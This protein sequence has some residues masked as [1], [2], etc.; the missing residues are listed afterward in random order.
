MES[1]HNRDPSTGE[2]VVNQG[3]T[4]NALTLVT[5]VQKETFKVLLIR[6][7]VG[8]QIA[9]FMME[10]K[11]FRDL[12]HCL[13][14][15]VAAYLPK[16]TATI[17]RWIMAAYTQRKEDLKEELQ[18]SISKV[19]IAFDIWTA[20]NWIGVICL[21]GYWADAAGKRQRRLLAFR[22]IYHSHDG[23]N[24]AAIIL[25]VLKEYEIASNVGYFV[26]DNHSANDSAIVIVLSELDPAITPTEIEG[27][28]LR[29]FGH[30]VNLAAQSLLDPS[31][32][33]LAVAAAELE[34]D[35]EAYE[36]SID[37][38]HAKGPLGKVCRLV[39]YVLASPQRREEF[40]AIK[41]GKKVI[42]YDHL[43]VS[44]D[45]SN[46]HELR[47]FTYEIHSFLL[48]FT[49]VAPFRQLNTLE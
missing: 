17:R 39:K 38:W 49:I 35:E 27:R 19:H 22:R 2:V 29:C 26:A 8:C 9:F 1:A 41:G 45:V 30:I 46:F 11:L 32:R 10:N 5:T 48:T 37:A 15:A 42:K 43:G 14:A 4:S 24:Q 6:W 28:R 21:W 25:E 16:A 33:E 3:T 40:A 34:I 13:N 36:R 20:G 12:I 47:T 18:L 31:A 7:I 23:E 44:I